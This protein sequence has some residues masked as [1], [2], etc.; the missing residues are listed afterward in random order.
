MPSHV[1]TWRN[2]GMVIVAI[3]MR[4]APWLQPTA[5]TVGTIRKCRFELRFVEEAAAARRVAAAFRV[6]GIG[7]DETT[8]LGNSALTSNL[9][10]QP[11]EGGPLEDVILRAAYCPMGGTSD[12][13]VKSV[14]QRCFARLRDML[15]R[16]EAK[17]REMFPDE[18]WTGP[19][20]SRVGLH[21][22]GG[23][24]AI[25]SDTCNGAR[26]SKKLLASLIAEQ[27]QSELGIDTWEAMTE[28][29]QEAATR[30]HLHDCWQHLRNIFLQEM[31]K[32]Q[33]AHM[34][35]ELKAELD[36]FAAWE[37]MSTDYSQ[38]LRATYKEFHQGCRYYKGKGRAY[39]AWL[40]QK[41]PQAF[42]IHIERADGGRQACL[43][44][45]IIA[46]VVHMPGSTSS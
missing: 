28:A 34:R 7:F 42:V 46:H 8:K 24:G 12:K 32:A 29:E 40:L 13:V 4:T 2:A 23:G 22:L 44:L 37:R 43:R 39:H 18:A 20:P 10:I 33:A 31:S 17:F 26:L 45:L 6:C 41:H 1:C 27:V 3:V 38:L 25:M 35:D 30:T 5:P 9:T 15:R 36:T 21:R 11:V 14:D 16:W 19:D